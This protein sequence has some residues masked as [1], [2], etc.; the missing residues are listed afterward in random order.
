MDRALLVADSSV[1]Q[2]ASGVADK[3]R[4][5]AAANGDVVVPTSK[6]A[7]AG[8]Q[9]RLLAQMANLSEME[10]VALVGWLEEAYGEAIAERFLMPLP[11]VA[12]TAPVSTAAPPATLAPFAPPTMAPSA[13]PS[14]SRSSIAA[15]LASGPPG[16]T[17]ASPVTSTFL[18]Y[19]RED[20]AAH[21]F[22]SGRIAILTF[23]MHTARAPPPGHESVKY[24]VD[25]SAM[26]KLYKGLQS[27][28][29]SLL[30]DLV[31]RESSTMKD[32]QDHFHRAVQAAE[33]D[34]AIQQRLSA[35]WMEL[36]QYFDSVEMMR[37]YYRKYLTVKSGRGLPKL[38]DEHIVMLVMCSE[39][40]R[41]RG[42][43]SSGAA[44]QEASANAAAE[45]AAKAAENVKELAMDLKLKFGELKSEVNNM[46]TEVK[47]LKEKVAKSPSASE[48]ECTYCGKKNHT[49][50]F[51]HKKIADEALANA[52]NQ[53]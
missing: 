42:C 43:G 19:Q 20:E 4:D 15:L 38:I 11:N 32:F 29:G 7:L 9:F 44:A 47:N 52:A 53:Q 24:G 21:G 26:T 5:A 23:L 33:G 13:M 1:T 25:P 18:P 35:H 48:K 8:A 41:A 16:P 31:T 6:G 34:S 2:L 17:P 22:D 14:A 10:G 40:E 3:L 36:S 50:A 45:R 30:W 46:R 37:T 27:S 28:V 39:L 12:L 49:A 51:C